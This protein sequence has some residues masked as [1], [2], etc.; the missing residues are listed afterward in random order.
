[1]T[2]LAVEK[3]FGHSMPPY[4]PHT[5]TAHLPGWQA[6]VSFRDGDRSA[7]SLIKSIYPRFTPW[8]HARQVRPT[9]P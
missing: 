8:G 1:M 3:K 4:G 6:L 7:M 9:H 2:S 5:I